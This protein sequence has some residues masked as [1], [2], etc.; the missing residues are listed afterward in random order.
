MICGLPL[1]LALKAQ[2]RGSSTCFFC[3][4]VHLMS[5]NAYSLEVLMRYLASSNP[6]LFE[7]SIFAHYVQNDPGDELEILVQFLRYRRLQHDWKLRNAFL[8]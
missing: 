3:T 5:Y 2:G 1:G 4:Y 8:F 6:L 7:A